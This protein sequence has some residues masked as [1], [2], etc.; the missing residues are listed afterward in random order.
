MKTS[1][2]TSN[3]ELAV[4]CPTC[5]ASAGQLCELSSGGPRNN[6]HRNRKDLALTTLAKVA[7]MADIRAAM[8][9]LMA[10]HNDEVE[11]LSREDF[12]AIKE[13]R[14]TLRTARDHKANLIELYREHVTS[15]G[16]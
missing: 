7:F 6:P 4:G 5:G 16:C 3:Q 13:L 15:C 8:G 14:K 11:A 2:L 9:S 1:D 12:D 10:I